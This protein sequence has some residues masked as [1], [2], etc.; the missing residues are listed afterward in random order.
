MTT[1]QN[2]EKVVV[3]RA[4]TDLASAGSVSVAPRR[5]NAELQKVHRLLRGR[6]HWAILLSLCFSTG[7][8]W[9]GLHF[10]KKTYQ[11]AGIVRLLAVMPKVMY[12]VDDKGVLPMYEQFADS[13]VTLIKSQRVL[14]KASED[15]E[16]RALK[17][18]PGQPPLDLAANLEVIRTGEMIWVKLNSPDPQSAQ[19]GVNCIIR[20]FEEV[21]AEIEAKS[22][23][24]RRELRESLRT[25]LANK[26]GV[27]RQEIL[28][29]AKLHGS[30]DLRP[31]YMFKLNEVQK[32]EAMMGETR[33]AIPLAAKQAAAASQPSTH[34]S[35]ELSVDQIASMDQ[36][37]NQYLSERDTIR[38]RII[39]LKAKGILDSNPLMVEAQASL[40][41]AEDDIVQRARSI[42]ER[43][44]RSN[45]P[46]NEAL[47]GGSNM[48]TEELLAERLRSYTDMYNAASL[49]LKSL[50][51]QRLQLD[52]LRNK[53]D[54]V[55]QELDETNR[56]I[57]QMQVESQ[58]SA[59]VVPLADATRPTI[60]LRDTRPSFAA[61][62]A[63]GGVSLGFGILLAVGF[64]NQKMQR[65]ED[66]EYGVMGRVLGVL[67]ELPED[68][69]DT[70]QQGLA[71]HCVH[72]IR[73][74][75]LIAGGRAKT[76]VFGITSPTAGSGKTSLTLAL[77]ISF[78]S[79]KLRTLLIDCDLVG[80]GLSTRVDAI[81]HR[82]LGQI[83]VRRKLINEA[84]LQK[85]VASSKTSGNKLGE[86]LVQLGYISAEDLT[87]ALSRQL[88]DRLGLL[89]ALAGESIEQCVAR[90]GVEHLDILPLGHANAQHIGRLA[91]HNLH[92]LIEA[93]R[94][95]YDIVLVDTGPI[96]GSLESS[97]VASQVDATVFVVSRGE[98]RSLVNRSCAELAAVSRNFAGVVF[99]RAKQVDIYAYDSKSR[100]LSVRSDLGSVDDLA[101]N[102]FDMGRLSESS[103]LG[104]VA[105]AVASVHGSSDAKAE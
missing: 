75:L 45:R 96:L 41:N 31:E 30:D 59:R 29:S 14:D 70:E 84:Q 33:I 52:D 54:V 40:L 74:R 57:D 8:I 76:Q 1:L 36:R 46:L 11:S 98:L 34:P 87:G 79:A 6:Y 43:M 3:E 4:M 5:Q 2:T 60:P 95:R 105:R 77:G 62:G 61:A 67:P 58:M 90:T 68:M 21:Y 53:A 103:R 19:V 24:R 93:A 10:G 38:H 15:P 82:K 85:A 16:F 80:G 27:L 78:A 28:D 91:P 65:P 49:E 42:R 101:A 50:G 17:P 89:D 35:E 73:T 88:V 63:L 66:A 20:A 9:L 104:P 72:E 7:G 83:L 18:L 26:Y 92:R 55:K 99:N 71:S 12:S 94:E 100:I 102:S 22:G 23:D 39:S 56:A 81:I 44:A 32:L 69:A 13:Q 86:A 37:M 64:V 25:T 51:V 47:A 48:N 97:I